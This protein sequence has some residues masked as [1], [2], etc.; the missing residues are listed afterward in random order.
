MS[1]DLLPLAMATIFV[2]GGVAIQALEKWADQVRDALGVVFVMTALF[3]VATL[4]AWNDP[5][6]HTDGVVRPVASAAPY[7]G[8]SPT[9]H[10]PA[11]RDRKPAG[12]DTVTYRD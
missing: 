11:V 7:D 1:A 5:R 9:I 12:L 8:M 2:A 6:S 4:M 10:A 3:A